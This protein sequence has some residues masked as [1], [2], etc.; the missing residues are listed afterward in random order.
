MHNA[1]MNNRSNI[2]RLKALVCEQRAREATD[3]AI[4]QSWQELAIEW[5][6][7]AHANADDDALQVQFS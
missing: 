7:I 1:A 5:H 4:K 2:P 6:A 3:P